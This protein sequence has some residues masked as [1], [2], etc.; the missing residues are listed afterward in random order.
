MIGVSK[1]LTSGATRLLSTT[2]PAAPPLPEIH[3]GSNVEHAMHILSTDLSVRQTNVS[4][5]CWTL[6][7]LIPSLLS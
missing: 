4:F 6:P 1:A 3:L 5:S 7:F 2:L